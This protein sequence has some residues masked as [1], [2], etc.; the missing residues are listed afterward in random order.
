[1]AG[2]RAPRCGIGQKLTRLES[3]CGMEAGAVSSYF[4]LVDDTWVRAETQARGSLER[5]YVIAGLAVRF[6]F[7]GPALLPLITPA[8]SH[9]ETSV[10][11]EPVLTVR[12]W[13]CASTGAAMPPAPTPLENFTFRGE[14]DGFGDERRHV[15]YDRVGRMLFL[16]DRDKKLSWFCAH[17]PATIPTYERGAPLRWIFGWLMQEHRRQVA[18][19][20]GIGTAMG[21]VLVVG[22]GGTGKSNTSVGCMLGGLDFAG[23]DFCVVAA[24]PDPVAYSLYSSAKLRTGDWARIPL[25]RVNVYDPETEKSLYY[26]NPHYAAR[27]KP[28][29]PILAI[30]LP[31]RDGMR[32]TSFEPISPRIPLIEIASQSIAMLPNAGAEAVAILSSLVRRLP[33]Y[34]FHLGSSPEHIPAAVSQLIRSLVDKD[35]GSDRHA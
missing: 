20:A 21:G 16:H 28:R 29:I 30:L 6:Q 23:D 10:G 9:L 11:R 35:R 14:L 13:D 12:L 15:A 25:P 17:D 4:K 7:A 31:A 27:I 19:A 3:R 32:E 8:L 18:H 22:R 24:E 5:N 26:L 1:M 34:R 33:C 2:I